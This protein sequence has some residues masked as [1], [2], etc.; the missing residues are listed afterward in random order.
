MSAP[1]PLPP[2]IANA[3][4]SGNLLEAIKLLRKS[5]GVGLAEAKQL[6]EAHMRATTLGSTAPGHAPRVAHKLETP[7]RAS[8]LSPGEV[9]R[10]DAGPWA[11]ILVV[12][13]AVVAFFWL[14]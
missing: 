12:A 5:K 14:P 3:L 10:S 9:P 7:R 8:N 11:I 1:S 4:R 2:D 13:V 6:I